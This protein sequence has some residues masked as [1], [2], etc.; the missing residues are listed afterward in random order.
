MMK[1]GLVAGLVVVGTMLLAC[2]QTSAA[3][4]PAA[5]TASSVPPTLW[6]FLGLKQCADKCKEHLILHKEKKAEKQALQGGHP[7]LKHLF[8]QHCPCPCA[9]CQLLKK[10]PLKPLADAANLE[11]QNPAIKAAAELKAEEDLT[12]QKIKAIRYLATIGCGCYPQVKPALLAALDDCIEEVRYEAALAFCRSAGNPCTVCNSSTC[13]APDVRD[14]LRDLAV[15]TDEQ[16]CWKEPSSRV[17]SAAASAL[18]MCEMIAPSEPELS[19]EEEPRELPVPETMPGENGAGTAALDAESR[20]P[21]VVASPTGAIRLSDGP[22]GEPRAATSERSPADSATVH[23][24]AS[25]AR[26]QLGLRGVSAHPV[27]RSTAGGAAAPQ[28]SKSPA[29]QKPGTG[30]PGEPGAPGPPWDEEVLPGED[31]LAPDLLEPS[32]LDLAGTF[33]AAPGPHSAAPYMIGDFFG[34]TGCQVAVVRSFTFNDL[35]VQWGQGNNFY[36]VLQDQDL[37]R[38]A[39]HDQYPNVELP[40]FPISDANDAAGRLGGAPLEPVPAGGTFLEGTTTWQDAPGGDGQTE[41]YTSQF[42]MGYVVAVASPG[43]GGGVGRT[44]IAENTSPMPRDR[45]IF[46]YSYFDNVPLAPGGIGVNRFNVG[47]EK[48]FLDGN[49]SFELK[50]PMASTVDSTVVQGFAVGQRSGEFGNL[51]LAVKALLRE[52]ETWAVSGGLQLGLPTADDARVV[53][54]DGTP[55]LEIQNDAVRLAPFLGVLWSP[56]ERLFSQGFLQC[57][58]ATNGNAVLVN[59][60]GWR[61]S[62]VGRLNDANLLTVDWGVGYWAMRNSCRQQPLT[63]L[64]WTAELHWTRSLQSADVV[65]AGPWAVTCADQAA[66]GGDGE[67]DVL[68]LTLGCHLAWRQKTLVT[69]GYAVPL[70]AGGAD[71]FDGEFRVMVNHHFGSANRLTPIF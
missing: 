18:N 44:K 13:C 49:M 54:P 15:G 42:Q 61:L 11:S 63:G 41:L 9:K 19:P 31:E 39:L 45:L 62:E 6:S 48:T 52:T 53:L 37:T 34:G 27:G 67:I 32:P 22:P 8:G 56:N 71:P 17:R 51:A 26:G 1:S 16:G 65:E 25:N 5:P 50:A 33:G 4:A 2:A 38:V 46:D 40:G 59:S 14:K 30:K 47:F 64:A 55:L 68:N 3:E 43:S 35:I 57:D 7:C 28:R 36:T 29:Q 60:D 12:P 21:T 70:Y 69:C 10:P 58:I 20:A 23:A 24:V 66:S